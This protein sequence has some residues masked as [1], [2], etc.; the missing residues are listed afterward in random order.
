MVNQRSI[1]KSSNRKIE[2]WSNTEVLLSD[3]LTSAH[4]RVSED[5]TLCSESGIRSDYHLGTTWAPIGKTPVVKVTGARFSLNMISAV[6]ALGHFRFM[7][8]EGRVNAMVF[9]EFS[10]V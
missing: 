6:N 10:N 5:K 3:L 4:I 1:L 2:R 8:V 9:R 7:T